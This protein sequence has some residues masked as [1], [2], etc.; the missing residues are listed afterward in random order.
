M[1]S[2]KQRVR[3]SEIDHTTHLTLTGIVNYFQDCSTFQSED[4]GVGIEY[5]EK[6]K[7]GWI[8]SSWQIIVKRYP[9]LGEEL[10]V[11]TW[12]TAFNGLYGTRNFIMKDQ[13]GEVIAYANSIWVFMDR[14]KGR[15]AKPQEEDIR[16]YEIEPELPMEYAPRKI[17]LPKEWE[18]RPAFPVRKS[19]IDTNGHVNN[20]RYIEMA[21]ELLSKEMFTG[22]IRVEYKKSAMYGDMICPM[23][24]EEEMKTIVKLCDEDGGLFAAVEFTGEKS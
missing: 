17:V 24:H 7:K 6:H 5:W 22:Q 13:S 1:Y 10:E 15:P 4:I 9:K 2:I 20:S 23:I 18:S 8:L 11:G 16:A 21:L 14:E 3:Y 12:P 19:Q